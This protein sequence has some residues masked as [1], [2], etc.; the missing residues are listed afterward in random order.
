MANPLFERAAESALCSFL[1]YTGSAALSYAAWGLFTPGPFDEWAA[2]GYGGLAA[3]AYNSGCQWDPDKGKTE[4]K[5]GCWSTPT[6]CPFGGY[7]DDGD[8]TG[9]RYHAMQVNQYTQ[10]H[11]IESATT[12]IDTFDKLRVRLRYVGNPGGPVEEGNATASISQDAGF[13]G[14][15]FDPDAGC[16][17][18]DDP[19]VPFP[20][21][22]YA[23]PDTGCNLTVSFEGFAVQ[24]GGA[25]SIAWK[26]EPAPVPRTGGGIIGGCNFAPVIYVSPPGGGGGG[27]EIPYYPEP[28]GPGGEPWWMGVLRSTLGGVVGAAVNQLLN[29]L[30]QQQVGGK[31]YRITS[32]CETDSQGEPISQSVEVDIP[33][34]PWDEAVIYRLDALEHIMQGLKDFKQPICSRSKPVGDFV[35]VHF[36]SDAPSIGGERPLRKYL[37]YRDQMAS[38]LAAHAAHWENFAWEAG[39]AIVIHKNAP[40]G[41]VK[42]WAADADEGKRVIRHAGTISGINVDAEGEWLVTSSDDP[43][44]GRT[45]TMRL[46]RRKGAQG[47]VL[48]ISKRGGPDGLPIVP[49][50]PFP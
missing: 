8:G 7:W 35:T 34:M 37:R 19:V 32:V 22:D 23:D 38:D 3:L 2:L 49:V 16:A 39:P 44:Y 4:N 48:T 11:R 29:E 10:L 30:L 24:D 36:E 18:S 5:Q 13:T 17:C 26:I 43:R 20:P 28:D 45:G 6:T 50:D 40:W 42:V 33:A 25:T 12:F 1:G 41:I 27:T 21:H 31:V 47:M 46:G 9:Y 14:V 15:G